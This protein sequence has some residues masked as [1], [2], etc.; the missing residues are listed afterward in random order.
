MVDLPAIRRLA[1]Q[2]S[3]AS[4]E[5]FVPA[6]L[7]VQSEEIICRLI[8]RLLTLG[9]DPTQEQVQREIDGAV[10]Q[11]NELDARRGPWIMTIER[12]DICEVLL[13]LV[14][15]CGFDDSEEW[16]GERDW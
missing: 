7:V 10:R 8:E 14:S 11:F 1:G 12:E 13:S 15:L 9:S 16:L 6:D 2:R 3:F 4:W 5:E